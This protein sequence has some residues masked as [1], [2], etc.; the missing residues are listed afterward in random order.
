MPLFLILTGTP[1]IQ[2][3]DVQLLHPFEA[4]LD[5]FVHFFTVFAVA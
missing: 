3:L 2:F 4:L 5:M 1:L